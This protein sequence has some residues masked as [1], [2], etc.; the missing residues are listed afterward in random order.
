MLASTVEQDVAFGPLQ[1]GVEESEA[2]HLG[3]QALADMAIPHLALRTVHEL[4]LG[5]KKRVVL[6]GLLVQAPGV[7]LL[8][9]PTAGLYPEGARAL[10][11]T[12]DALAS[13]GRAF[14]LATHNVDFAFEWADEVCVRFDHIMIE[15]TGLADPAP[16]AQTF[17]VDDEMKERMALDGIVTLVDTKHI[18]QH[19]DDSDEAK[20]QVAFA[21]VILLNKIDLVPAAELDKLEARIRKMNPAARIYRTRDAAIDM[22]KILGLGGFNLDRALQVDPM[23]LEP[24]YPFEWG[25]VYELS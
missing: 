2:R 4:S 1:S 25:G 9:E 18:W 22:D 20:E 23:F 11:E 5:E 8:D 3:E 16:I 12:L 15:T 17:F 14:V 19:I 13:A 10:R 6:A 24:E 21:D 7:L